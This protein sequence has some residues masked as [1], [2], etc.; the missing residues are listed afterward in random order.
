M[1][2]ESEDKKRLLLEES[3]QL[4]QN[5]SILCKVRTI[6]GIKSLRQS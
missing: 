3:K 5:T 6:D 1:V 2:S 4:M